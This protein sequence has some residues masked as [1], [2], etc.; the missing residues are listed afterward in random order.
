[1]YW[2]AGSHN[3]LPTSPG[4]LMKVL[5]T[6]AAGQLGHGRLLQVR[7]DLVFDGSQ[8]RPHAPEQPRQALLD[9]LKIVVDAA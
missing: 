8:G 9:V 3:D 4:P 7:T 5:L 2:L 1:M 6:G